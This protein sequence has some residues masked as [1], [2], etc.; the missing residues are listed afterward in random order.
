MRIN[1]RNNRSGLC[2]FFKQCSNYLVPVVSSSSGI[3]FFKLF[4][5]HVV[6][7][8]YFS[9]REMTL[10]TSVSIVIS[11]GM[12]AFCNFK[13]LHQLQ[14]LR[15]TVFSIICE[16]QHVCK[17][18]GK[19]ICKIVLVITVKKQRGRN[20]QEV[21]PG[22]Y[23]GRVW[24]VRFSVILPLLSSSVNPSFPEVHQLFRYRGEKRI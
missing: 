18:K 14:L 2:V 16:N 12:L 13:S 19:G 22:L 17:I 23:R 5:I 20:S 11:V 1:G 24:M 15:V 3:L 7:D 8:S 10:G 4:L 21:F 9:R 6:F